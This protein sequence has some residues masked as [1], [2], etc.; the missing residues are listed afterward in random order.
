VNHILE[1]FGHYI[2][3]LWIIVL[4][5]LV[6][7]SAFFSGAET[8]ITA[9][10]KYKIRNLSEKKNKNARILHGLLER[11]GRVITTLLIGS[12]IANISAS[13]LATA[14]GIT[15]LSGY[16]DIALITSVVT[17]L[18]TIIIIIFGEIIPK[19]AAITHSEK[20][21][22]LLAP[23]VSVVLKLMGPISSLLS[24]ISRLLIRLFGGPLPEKGSLLTTEELQMMLK[25]SEEEGIIEEEEKEM[26]QG[27]FELSNIIVREIM[28]PR[29]DMA[30]VEINATI[31][32]V[33]DIAFAS[34]HSRIPVYE[35]VIDNVKGI[36]YIKDLL[37]VT[38]EEKK[39]GIKKYLR[40]AYYVP[41]T[42]KVDELLT[43]MRI[44]KNHIAIVVD[45]Y[46]GTSGVVSIED[47]LEEIVGDIQ[48]E[49]DEEEPPMVKK[50]DEHLYLFSAKVSIWEIDELLEVS[51]PEGEDYDTLGGFLCDVVGEI[52]HKDRII[53]WENLTF[54]VVEA[55]KQQILLVQVQVHPL[56]EQSDENEPRE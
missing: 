27:I 14:I 55:S 8:A 10:N 50:I 54:K 33:I 20:V 11:P 45:E 12:N 25:V 5:L 3:Y 31:A 1:L 15:Y 34:G 39:S 47:I 40:E 49:Y 17:V 30:C 48:D 6:I 46:G 4:V 7:L 56:N 35:E 37:K 26:I 24:N 42:K 2:F 9:V 43:K 29:I 36:I 21:S 23:V 18:M 53:E 38:N 22:L 44:A 41:E 19:N 16:F 13:A 52:P 28:T 51:I 32:D